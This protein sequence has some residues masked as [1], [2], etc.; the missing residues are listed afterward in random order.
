MRKTNVQIVRLLII[1]KIIL[2][3]LNYQT[4]KIRANKRKLYLH[5]YMILHGQPTWFWSH[6]FTSNY[7]KN[8]NDLQIT[9]A[10][11]N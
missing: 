1:K 8:R 11:R 2:L 3:I 6:L 5:V 4:I 10:D 7:T 9:R